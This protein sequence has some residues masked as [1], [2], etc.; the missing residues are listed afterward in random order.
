MLNNSRCG[1]IKS[2]AAKTTIDGLLLLYW[3]E[4][5]STQCIYIQHTRKTSLTDTS[6]ITWK[7]RPAC[8]LMIFQSRLGL[9]HNQW[10]FAREYHCHFAASLSAS[11][12]RIV[13][14]CDEDDDISACN[15]LFPHWRRKTNT[16][17]YGQTPSSPLS[18]FSQFD[19]LIRL[20]GLVWRIAKISQSSVNHELHLQPLTLWYYL[21][22]IYI[23]RNIS[24]DLWDNN[25]FGTWLY[26]DVV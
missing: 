22:F 8:S 21:V 26:D 9:G 20:L 12:I 15:L 17:W 14:I 13:T 4:W 5:K 3:I 2:V 25:R 11:N 24:I 19:C 1:G 6:H 23:F 7:V 18:L 10:Q 16:W